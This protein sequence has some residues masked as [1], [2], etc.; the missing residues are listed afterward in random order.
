MDYYTTYTDGSSSRALTVLLD[1]STIYRERVCVCHYI[2]K[3]LGYNP[4]KTK[5]VYFI[6]HNEGVDFYYS[7]LKNEIVIS[8]F[9][10][11]KEKAMLA[12]CYLL[13]SYGAT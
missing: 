13:K 12:I 10:A 6:G 1:K 3:L 11:F 9:R 4:L 2:S 5:T 8:L 7:Q